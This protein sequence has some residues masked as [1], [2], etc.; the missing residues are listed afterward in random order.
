MF[1]IPFAY[2]CYT[3]A[4]IY[5]RIIPGNRRKNN[6]LPQ[7][8]VNVLESN[9]SRMLTITSGELTSGALISVTSFCLYV[10]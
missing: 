7:N 5:D 4:M 3:C 9:S 2:R 6:F 8:C 1:T 10:T